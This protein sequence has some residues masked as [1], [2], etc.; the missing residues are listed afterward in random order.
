MFHIDPPFWGQPR[1]PYVVTLPLKVVVGQ[2]D[3]D[4]E[5]LLMRR[6]WL[7]PGLGEV[8]CRFQHARGSRDMGRI[9][10]VLASGHV[11]GPVTYRGAELQATV[12]RHSQSA[13]HR[14]GI[15]IEASALAT[16]FAVI[17]AL[18]EVDQVAHRQS[19]VSPAAS[20]MRRLPVE[21]LDVAG[22]GTS[23]HHPSG[24]GDGSRITTAV[25]E[26]RRAA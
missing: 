21:A 12:T 4:P 19:I 25:S 11:E 23:M 20:G 5:G 3:N 26:D 9:R 1:P 22:V 2:E 18:A 6:A 13:G 17:L 7:W 16:S 10:R 24:S 15:S 14:S 8:I